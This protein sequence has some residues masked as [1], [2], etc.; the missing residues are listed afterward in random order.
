[1]R[2]EDRKGKE[3][4]RRGEEE[5]KGERAKRRRGESPGGC[6]GI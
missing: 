3:K 4:G 2:E 1:M 6:G 5:S